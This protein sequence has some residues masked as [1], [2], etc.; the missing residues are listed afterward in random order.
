MFLG[1]SNIVMILGKIKEKSWIERELRGILEEIVEE[2]KE[3]TF[4]NFR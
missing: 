4:S 1:N 2:L 3:E